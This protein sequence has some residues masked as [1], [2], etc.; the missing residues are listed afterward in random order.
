MSIFFKISWR[1]LWRNRRRTVVTLLAIVFAT[2]LFVFTRGMQFGTYAATIRMTA[3]QFS[4]YL[5]IQHPEYLDNPG[6]H[7]SFRLTTGLIDLLKQLPAVTGFAPRLYAEGLAGLKNNSVGLTLMGI[8]P[9]HEKT[10]T[11]LHTKVRKGRFLASDS[12]QEVVV[13]ETLLKNL[14][15]KL[16]DQI[17]VLSQGFDGSLGNMKFTIVGV[18][19]TG[20]AELDQ[21]TAIMGLKDLQ[22][23][24]TMDNRIHAIVINLRQ[25]RD[26]PETRQQLQQMLPPEL[27]VRSWDEVVPDL[28]QSIELDNIGGLLFLIILV[29]VVAFGILNTLLMSVT[30]RFRE[31]GVLLSLGLSNLRL[32]QIV[33]LESLY[34]TI[35]G[36]AI[37]LLL[38][39]AANYYVVLHP[40]P[41]G[42][43]L[44]TIS[45]E[46][47]FAPKIYSTVEA[48][49]FIQSFQYIFLIA[50]L[51]TLY[52]IYKVMELEPLKGIRYT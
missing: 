45:Q 39:Y 20:S 7:K 5:Q 34:L 11:Q 38:G 16:G 30:E 13:G 17:V 46:Y 21:Y 10:V 44:A 41:L 49:I 47:G 6:L 28:K 51:A 23:L 3:E 35:M 32:A 4:G 33:F 12:S 42:E 19:K 15:G 2:F 48:R 29:I 8:D 25:L 36:I 18:I 1:N 40:I 24:L 37:G 14:G 27:T 52:P 22:E 9:E 31:F 43:E 50:L 26:L